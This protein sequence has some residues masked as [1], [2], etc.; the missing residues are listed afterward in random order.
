MRTLLLAH[1]GRVLGIVFALGGLRRRVVG[2]DHDIA[3]GQRLLGLDRRQALA[4]DTERQSNGGHT[5]QESLCLGHVAF[6]RIR[7]VRPLDLNK[8]LRDSAGSSERNDRMKQK[9][10]PT[11]PARLLDV[12]NDK[13]RSSAA[14]HM[15]EYRLR[16]VADN[17]EVDIGL[18]HAGI[19]LLADL[20]AEFVLAHEVLLHHAAMLVGVL[21]D[22]ELAGV[23]GI[24]G[25]GKAKHDGS[26]DS[27]FQ[28]HG[29]PPV[30]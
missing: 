7:V 18:V 17:L 23:V 20:H 8:P 21:D 24:S 13:R 26:G 22:D 16:V 10:G 11:M 19:A 2:H 3:G 29:V 30:W 9:R 5:G 14:L 15:T 4:G 27:I 25:A 12:E 6:P 28:S 1:L